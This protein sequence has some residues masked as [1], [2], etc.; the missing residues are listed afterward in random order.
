M[1]VACVRTGAKYST[2]YVL[3]L[4]AGVARHMP[5]PYRFV[6]LTD[7][8]DDFVGV[9]TADIS[10]TGLKGWWGKMALFDFAARQGERI[11]YLD[12]D[13]VIVGDLSPL[14]DLDVEFGIC[15]NFTRASGNTKYPCRYGSCVMTI[16]PAAGDSIW[17]GFRKAQGRLMA[18][19]GTYGDQ[20]AIERLAPS[21]TLLQ[22]VL[23]PGFF[24]GYRDLA[25]ARPDGCSLVIFAGNAKPHNCDEKWIRE[26]WE[27]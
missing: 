20:H 11:V 12:L 18:E 2:D 24:L 21:A 19:A 4:E 17:T 16:G 22:D 26:A 3:R 14:A 9:R 15:G 7:R 27:A 5:R 6:C 10:A 25:E 8:P 13:T 23:P 1:I